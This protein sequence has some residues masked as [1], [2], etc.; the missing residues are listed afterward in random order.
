M[1]RYRSYRV[2]QG[3]SAASARLLWRGPAMQEIVNLPMLLNSHNLDRDCALINDGRFSGATA[4]L[5]VG[6]VSPEAASGGMIGLV[7]D[8]DPIEIDLPAR[9]LRLAVP[10]GELAARRAAMEARGRTEWKPKNPRTRQVSI[11]LK[12]YA[13]LATSADKGAVRDLSADE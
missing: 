6:H 3:Q 10:V 5:S 7:E 13:L 4:G 12:A 1:T 2:T 11:G 8:G 9:S